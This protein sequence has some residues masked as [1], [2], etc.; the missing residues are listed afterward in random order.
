MCLAAILAAVPSLRPT[1]P[2]PRPFTSLHVSRRAMLCSAGS[3]FA[4]LPHAAIAAD[5]KRTGKEGLTAAAVVLQLAENTAAMQGMLVQS[6]KD[7][8]TMSESERIDAGMPVIRR[9]DLVRSVDIML[10]NSD[11]ANIPKGDEAAATI[12]GITGIAKAGEGPLTR[13]ECIA[14]ARQYSAAR[15]ELKV[16]FDALTVEQQEEGKAITRRLRERDDERQRE[17]EEEEMR[18]Q[19]ARKKLQQAPVSD[20]KAPRAPSKGFTD[21]DMAASAKALYG[22]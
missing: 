17:A 19:L 5:G 10:R 1:H 21:A 12:Y 15:A 9:E 14:V 3:A 22:S 18:I 7:M 8:T 13:D 6:A 11:L 2:P 4:L 16:V 20:G